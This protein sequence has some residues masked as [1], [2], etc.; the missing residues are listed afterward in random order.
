MR[1]VYNERVRK[2]Y[3]EVLIS[4]TFVLG[5]TFLAYS[6]LAHNA[7]FWNTQQIWSVGLIIGWTVVAAE[8]FRQ[9]W[10]IHNARTSINISALLPSTIFVMQCILFFKGVFFQDWSLIISALTVNS[11]VVFCLYQIMKKKRRRTS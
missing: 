2:V 5:G 11:G 9:G 3:W 6:W 10:M 4:I 7:F 1:T 8:Y